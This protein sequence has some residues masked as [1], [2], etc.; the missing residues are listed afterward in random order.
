MQFPLSCR[1]GRVAKTVA[2]AD[3]RHALVVKMIMS[4]L[5]PVYSSS[6]SDNGSNTTFQQ[7]PLE[8]AAVFSEN[9][10]LQLSS[11][12]FELQEALPVTTADEIFG[13]TSHIP[14]GLISDLLIDLAS[15]SMDQ[16]AAGPAEEQ[17]TDAQ[18]STPTFTTLESTWSSQNISGNICAT[19]EYQTLDL[20]IKSLP[21]VISTASDFSGTIS[22]VKTDEKNQNAGQQESAIIEPPSPNSVSQSSS[23]VVFTETVNSEGNA[24][25]KRTISTTDDEEHWVLPPKRRPG[26]KP[27]RPGHPKRRSKGEEKGSMEYMLKRARN[28]I[29]IRKCREKAKVKQEETEK[30]MLMLESENELLKK[31]NSELKSSLAALKK[32]LS[33]LKR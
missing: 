9:D 15:G 28:N 25:T 31:E 20:S 12:A 16:S 2:A 24:P 6:D 5:D 14:E 30:R 22:F 3:D 13:D 11:G 4:S 27:S 1:M 18:V 32:E 19:S 21:T 17:R 7:F 33:Q 29:A 10:P 23:T 8:M 26:R